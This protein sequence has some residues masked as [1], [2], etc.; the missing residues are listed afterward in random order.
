MEKLTW[1]KANAATDIEYTVHIYNEMESAFSPKGIR[2]NY[3]NCENYSQSGLSFNTP[4]ER[5][6]LLGAL[7]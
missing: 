3:A 1:R 2:E 4:Q 5:E 6:N 7:M